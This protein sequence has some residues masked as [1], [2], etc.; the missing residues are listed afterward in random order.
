MTRYGCWETKNGNKTEI[1]VCCFCSSEAALSIAVGILTHQSAILV[2][3]LGAILDEHLIINIKC[4]I[5]NWGP[6]KC[7]EYFVTRHPSFTFIMIS[8]LDCCSSIVIPILGQRSVKDVRKTSIYEHIIL[9]FK[10]LYGGLYPPPPTFSDS[11]TNTLFE[12]SCH[13][14]TN[15]L[16]V[17][18]KLFWG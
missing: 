16:Q 7:S 1:M 10:Q 3:N 14:I 6:F 2:R 9:C 12:I 4:P 11:N 18:H 17:I 15:I 5:S 13:S 8:R